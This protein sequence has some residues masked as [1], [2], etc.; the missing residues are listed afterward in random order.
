MG[1]AVAKAVHGTSRDSEATFADQLSVLPG[2]TGSRGMRPVT[3]AETPER[4]LEN[5]H[6]L[7]AIAREFPTAREPLD[8]ASLSTSRQSE[9]KTDHMR[10]MTLHKAKELE[11][12]RAFLPSWKVG[13]FPPPYGDADEERRLAHVALTRGMRHVSIS[14]SG[15][16]H[17]PTGPSSFTE[18]IPPQ[19]CSLGWLL[20]P[21]RA[22][23][24]THTSIDWFD[25]QT[26]LQ[27]VQRRSA[28][29]RHSGPCQ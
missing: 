25:E 6:E 8:H 29:P 10:W 15:Y 2:A 26:L 13:V 18:D 19:H 27:R 17:E 12:P 1:L 21:A 3:R 23:Q 16:R 22:R 4:R 20:Q 7:I 14:F 9:D 5:M 11:F 24:Q 28:A